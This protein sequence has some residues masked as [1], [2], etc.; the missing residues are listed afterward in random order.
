M[1][2]ARNKLIPI[3]S[4]RG[5]AALSV[6]FGHAQTEAGQMSAS[7]APVDFPW[8]AGV[9]LFFVVSGFVMVLS[10][11]RLFGRR[12]GAAHFLTQRFLRIA[13]LY[14][15][16]TLAIIL[17]ALV[18][19]QELETTRLSISGIISSFAF[20]PWPRWDGAMRP[21]LS[22]GWTLNYEFFFYVVFSLTLFFSKT[23]GLRVLLATLALLTL[24][25]AS[26]VPLPPTL[27]FWTDP[28]LLEF[29]FGVV[30]GWL[31]TTRTFPPAP[32]L[33]ACLA[34]VGLALL[35]LSPLHSA[36]PRLLALGAPAGM[37]LAAAL[38][39]PIPAAKGLQA[40]FANWIGESSY[41]QYLS[42]PFAFGFVKLIWP[43]PPG[44][45]ADWLYV[46]V[47]VIVATGAGIASYQL[48]ER[49]LLRAMRSAKD[50]S[51]SRRVLAT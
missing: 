41:S 7:F 23:T 13:P 43:L 49:P 42:H 6:L 40:S 32:S 50:A 45:W 26:G 8:G 36:L 33:A 44:G 10:S 11:E 12:G 14:W 18:M 22:L 1:S 20:V 28:L 47:A 31:Y 29:A 34:T 38:L 17:V 51:A 39:T 48:I 19:P 5:I 24:V 9:D 37:L 46:F 16:F 27:R 15:L 4:L 21:M 3:Q 25:G 2:E 30:L 35:V